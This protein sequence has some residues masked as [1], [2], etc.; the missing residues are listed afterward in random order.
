MQPLAADQHVFGEQRLGALL[1]ARRHR[2]DD[3][4]V[5]LRGQ[6][7]VVRA[8][9]EGG[10]AVQV[11]LVDDASVLGEQ[12]VVARGARQQVVE[13]DVECEV[14]AGAPALMAPPR[15]PPCGARPTEGEPAG[16]AR[17][18]ASFCTRCMRRT[19]ARNCSISSMAM[20]RA[21]SLPI[22]PSSAAR[23]S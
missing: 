3:G 17:P 14:L 9:A 4:F 10:A 1:V 18:S 11:E 12:R 13:L 21:A 19:T 20:R 8:A 5:F 22:S 2:I 23:T 15:P 16:V 7:G 6:R